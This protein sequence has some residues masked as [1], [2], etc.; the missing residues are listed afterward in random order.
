MSLKDN[1]IKLSEKF[2]GTHTLIGKGLSKA[3]EMDFLEII[4]GKSLVGTR[5]SVS[6]PG[7]DQGF[8]CFNLRF[9]LFGFCNEALE[10]G[11]QEIQET[12]SVEST[13]LTVF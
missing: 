8:Q 10:R 1:Y 12:G 2:G 11:I 6:L 7:I 3:V 4:T 9:L 5:C 13:R